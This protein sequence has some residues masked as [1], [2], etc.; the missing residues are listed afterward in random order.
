LR[1]GKGR[2]GE[3]GSGSHEPEGATSGLKGPGSPIC[4]TL[5]RETSI[6]PSEKQKDKPSKNKKNNY[7]IRLRAPTYLRTIESPYN[8]ERMRVIHKDFL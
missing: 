2:V 4:H 6:E 7:L 5:P 8:G 3:R 1:E